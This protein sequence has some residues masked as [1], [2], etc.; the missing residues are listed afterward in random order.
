L[1]TG[2]GI[3]A[4]VFPSVSGRYEQFSIEAKL[5]RCQKSFV[6]EYRYDDAFCKRIDYCNL[7]SVTSKEK[8]LVLYLSS[9]VKQ[10]RSAT[11]RTTGGGG[12]EAILHSSNS[13]FD[14]FRRIV[15]R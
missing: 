3:N 2:F 14:G 8:C 9:V 10:K 13:I 7:P 1:L 5:L 6:F 15:G 12:K 4:D 11:E